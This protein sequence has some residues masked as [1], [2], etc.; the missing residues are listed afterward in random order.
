MKG[1]EP[2]GTADVAPDATSPVADD[3]A[4]HAD[5]TLGAAVATL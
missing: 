2:G 3:R 4:V 1:M 5:D